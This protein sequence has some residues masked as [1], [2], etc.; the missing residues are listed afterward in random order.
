MA[1]RPYIEV[2]QTV[3]PECKQCRNR[4]IRNTHCINGL[5]ELSSSLDS[6]PIRCVGDWANDKIWYLTRYFDTF[7]TSMHKKWSALHY[8]EICCGPGR[9]CTRDG[10]EQ[11]GTAL[12]VINNKG[13]QYLSSAT[14]IDYDK[15]AVETLNQRIKALNKEPKAFAKEGDYNNIASI[16]NAISHIKRNGLSLCFIDPT[17]CSIPFDTIKK[18]YDATGKKCDFIISFFSKTDFSRNGVMAATLP[19]HASLKHKYENFLGC[20]TFFERPDIISLANQNQHSKLVDV[21]AE[22]YLQQFAK[23]GLIYSDMV[24]IGSW[25]RLIFVSSNSVALNLWKKTNKEYT[26]DGQ[27]LLF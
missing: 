14:F 23:L 4:E 10:Y 26:P 3:L 9:C 11:D 2:R 25:Y 22:T 16:M 17:D 5:C 13:F 1:I 15:V 12:S 27:R 21:F 19:S 24:N 7:M 18:I 8:I 6:L 20:N